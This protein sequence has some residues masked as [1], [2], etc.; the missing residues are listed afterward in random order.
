MTMVGT[1]SILNLYLDSKRSSQVNAL[2]GF[3][4]ANQTLGGKMLVT[5]EANLNL[6]NAFGGGETLGL[7]WQQL[8]IQSPRLNILYQQPYIFHS[9]FGFDF[10]FDL[11]KKDSSFLNLNLILGL[12]YMVSQRTTGKIFLS[13]FS[14]QPDHC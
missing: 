5:G 7:N 11:F 9:R 13:K 3:L 12:Q 6:K 1:G 2:I 14:Y 4:P 8:Q 10:N